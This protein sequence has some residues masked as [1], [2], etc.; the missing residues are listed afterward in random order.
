M[1]CEALGS[2]VRPG[3]APVTAHSPEAL[4]V[5]ENPLCPPRSAPGP[6]PVIL[7][8]VVD[9]AR[10]GWREQMAGTGQAREQSWRPALSLPG[11]WGCGQPDMLVLTHGPHP[12]SLTKLWGSEWLDLS[13][14]QGKPEV[15]FVQNSQEFHTYD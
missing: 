15:I 7:S 6:H 2:R 3:T 1:S 4:L 14:F 5:L 12:P 8:E 11:A 9:Q 10:R 13:V